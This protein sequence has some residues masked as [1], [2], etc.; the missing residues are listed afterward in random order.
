[1]EAR[2]IKPGEIG[3]A[4]MYR[5]GVPVPESATTTLSDGTRVRH[6]TMGRGIQFDQVAAVW[7]PN[8][9]VRW[10]YQFSDDSFPPGSVDEHVLIGGDYFDVIDTEYALQPV[11]NGTL[12]RVRMSYRVSTAFN[13]YALPIARWLVGNFEETALGFYA[14]RAGG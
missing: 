14:Q 4:W 12:L 2:D 8:V 5:I 7:E 6:I 13:W 9:R 11:A 1:V 10:T 3:S